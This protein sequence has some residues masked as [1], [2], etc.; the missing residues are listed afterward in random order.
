MVEVSV[1]RTLEFQSTVA[2]VVESLVVDH[3]TLVSVLHQ[4]MEGEGCIVR[5]YDCL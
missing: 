3:V 1:T 2:D 5:L 4:L